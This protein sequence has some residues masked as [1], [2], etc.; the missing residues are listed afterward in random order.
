MSVIARAPD[1][2]IRLYCK[3]SDTKVMAK[4]RGKGEEP[5]PQ[6]H[7]RTE[8]NLSMFARQ[9]GVGMGG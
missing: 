5:Q 3:G 9:V 8:D 4:L 2:T 1:S 7:H 6:L